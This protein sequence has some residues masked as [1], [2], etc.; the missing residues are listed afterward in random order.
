MDYVYIEKFLS[1]TKIGITISMKVV[2]ITNN[3]EL[4]EII[5][6]LKEEFQ[7]DLTSIN[8]INDSLDVVSTIC[9]A[10]PAFLIFDDDL[11]QNESVKIL[12]SIRKLCKNIS[13]IFI[14]SD[15]SIEKGRE[16]APLGIQYYGVRP[17]TEEIIA[18]AMKSIKKFKDNILN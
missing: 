15:S 16:V 2:A 7:I 12:Q 4:I 3:I 5:Q 18:E 13:I 11:K 17:V 6:N 14:T 9:A 8:K 1:G 10:P